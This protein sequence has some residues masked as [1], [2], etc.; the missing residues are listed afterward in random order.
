MIK[1]LLLAITLTTSLCSAQ[2]FDFNTD[3]DFEGFT[4]TTNCTATVANGYLSIVPTDESLIAKVSN[5]NISVNADTNKYIHFFYKNLSDSNGAGDNSIGDGNDQLR[6]E[7]SNGVDYSGNNNPINI[8]STDFEVKTINATSFTWWSGTIGAFHLYPRRNNTGSDLHEIQITRIE[9]SNSATPTPL[10]GPAF[11]EDFESGTPDDLG[12]QNNGDNANLS[13]EVATI[14][15]GTTGNSSSNVLKI[16]ESATTENYHYP[17]MAT[18]A[19]DSNNGEY[20]S[21]LFLPG[22]TGTG[23]FTLRIRDGGTTVADIDQSYTATDLTTWIPISWDISSY[24]NSNSITRLDFWYDNG[25]RSTATPLVRYIDEVKQTTSTTLS[26]SSKTFKNVT[27]YPN[28]TTGE[29][30]IS[31]I[32]KINGDIIISNVLGQ[33]VKTVKAANT[34]NISDLP[35]GIYFLQTRNQLIKKVIKN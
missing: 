13:I 1:K 9:F 4:G 10:P 25:G 8:N 16:T 3:G 18:T 21:L 17:F 7:A 11:A 22:E 6:F 5:P 32:S 29:I 35:Q 20:I 31:D 28:P 33:V 26:S 23:T 27:V 24:I 2:I 19:L 12:V 15:S 30:N 14:P 34:I